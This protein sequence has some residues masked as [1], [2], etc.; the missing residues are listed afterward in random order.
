M[1]LKTIEIGTCLLEASE[2]KCNQN[3]D[4]PAQVGSFSLHLNNS[5]LEIWKIYNHFS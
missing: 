1:P 3:Q 4:F 2:G 5:I